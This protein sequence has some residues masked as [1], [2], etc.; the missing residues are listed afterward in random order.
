TKEGHVVLASESGVL[1][2]PDEDIIERWRL[3]PGRM[4][5]IDLEEGRIISDEEVKKQLSGKNPYAE[6]L[7]RSQIVLEDLPPAEPQGPKSTESLLDRM[8]A[9]G[10]T[11]ED[12]KL[13]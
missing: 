11:Q 3:Q 4:L 13:L 9:F 2:I 8:Q 10:Y 1:D 6:W 5:L 12:I 7:A